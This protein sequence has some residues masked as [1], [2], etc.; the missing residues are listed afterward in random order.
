M[1]SEDF[2]KEKWIE[3]ILCNKLTHSTDHSGLEYA[4]LA[5]KHQ[6]TAVKTSVTHDWR[7]V[8]TYQRPGNARELSQASERQQNF[9]TGLFPG[10]KLQLYILQKKLSIKMDS[11]ASTS[12]ICPFIFSW[13]LYICLSIMPNDPL[14]LILW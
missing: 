2:Y 13:L 6:R 10:P 14:I 7:G 5:E 12:W 11:N 4:Q 8:G 1:A 9:K 3:F